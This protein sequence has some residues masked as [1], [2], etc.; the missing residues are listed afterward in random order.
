MMVMPTLKSWYGMARSTG[1]VHLVLLL[2]KNDFD[3]NTLDQHKANANGQLPDLCHDDPLPP[4][5]P[6]PA[7]QGFIPKCK[8]N[9]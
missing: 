1:M 2:V 5:E 4:P 8:N 7:T 9:Y 6:P 3:G